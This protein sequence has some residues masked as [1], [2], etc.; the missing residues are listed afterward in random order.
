MRL[1]CPLSN[2]HTQVRQITT[3]TIFDVRYARI[4]SNFMLSMLQRSSRRAFGD[5]SVYSDKHQESKGDYLEP[6]DQESMP[7]TDGC[8]QEGHLESQP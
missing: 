1:A 8:Q 4:A 3:T 6:L 7:F 5:F 2:V